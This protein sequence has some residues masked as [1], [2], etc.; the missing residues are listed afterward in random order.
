MPVSA[1]SHEVDDI[2]YS[3]GDFAV[4]TG[5]IIR[6]ASR[7]IAPFNGCE[8]LQELSAIQPVLV[9]GGGHIDSH[10]PSPG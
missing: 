4:D 2:V 5:L 8:Y 3:V 6:Q 7:A 9:E 1:L 10:S